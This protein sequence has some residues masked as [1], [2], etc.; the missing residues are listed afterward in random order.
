MNISKLAA[1]A[2]AFYVVGTRADGKGYW[3]ADKCPDWVTTLNRAAH[4]DMLPDDYKYAFIVEALDAI[5]A[6]GAE[7]RWDIENLDKC[8]ITLEAD[9]YTAD[10]LAW[11]ASR[12][13]R[14]SYCDD[15]AR[16][17]SDGTSDFADTLARIAGGQY[18][19]KNEVLH[20]VIGSL[21]V[22]RD[23]RAEI[24]SIGDT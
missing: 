23:R 18:T 15:F 4:G 12:N 8:E 5:A 6:S 2:R 16:E 7:T 11:L 14:L 10:L 20:S 24:S 9:I 3:Y 1:E 13:D 17:M 19:E 22:E 21:S